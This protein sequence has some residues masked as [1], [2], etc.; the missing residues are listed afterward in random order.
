MDWK[1]QS[2]REWK[3][4]QERQISALEQLV[5]ETK[6]MHITLKSGLVGVQDDIKALTKA[7]QKMNELLAYKEWDWQ[8][9]YSPPFSTLN[10][11]PSRTSKKTVFPKEE[12]RK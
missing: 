9:R 1:A 11:S 6:S 8:P 10:L 2:E 7:I 12:S 3:S 5:E 4:P